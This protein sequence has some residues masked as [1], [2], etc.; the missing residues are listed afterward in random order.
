MQE[1]EAL[2]PV[3]IEEQKKI[4]G[5]KGGS[6]LEGVETAYLKRM[7]CVSKCTPNRITYIL[8]DTSFFIEDLM[9]AHN[10]VPALQ[11]TRFL[12]D[13]R[14]KSRNVHQ[15]LLNTPAMTSSEWKEANYLLRHLYTRVQ[16][17][18]YTT[19]YANLRFP[20]PERRMP[21]HPMRRTVQHVSHCRMHK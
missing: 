14:Q 19:V 4:L 21:M 17:T 7:L 8:A 18:E 2:N 13:R 3:T 6:W 11:S 20:Q 12:E 9:A 5:S 10:L 15:G 16:P 1:E